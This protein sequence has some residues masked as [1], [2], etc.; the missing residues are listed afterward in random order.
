MSGRRSRRTRGEKPELVPPKSDEEAETED[1]DSDEKANETTVTRG[2]GRRGKRVGSSSSLPQLATASKKPASRKKASAKATATPK[3]K[4]G[5]PRGRPRTRSPTPSESSIEEQEDIDDASE[6]EASDAE[7]SNDPNNEGSEEDEEEEDDD[8]DAERDTEDDAPKEALTGKKKSTRKSRKKKG[9]EEADTPHPRY[10]NPVKIE[11]RNCGKLCFS[12][13]IKIHEKSCMPVYTPREDSK[14]DEASGS[15]DNSSDSSDGSSSP[16]VTARKNT[17]LCKHCGNMV[18]SR[19]F[20]QHE[21][22]CKK[23]AMDRDDDGTSENDDM[24]TK[25]VDDSSSSSVVEEDPPKKK[26]G[27]KPKAKAAPSEDDAS[28]S[29]GEEKPAKRK[30]GRKATT[31]AGDDDESLSQ[32]EKRPKKRG[33]PP[34][35]KQAADSGDDDESS[36]VVEKPPKKRGRTP[37]SKQGDDSLATVGEKTQTKRGRK[38]KA[39]SVKASADDSSS[40]SEEQP[41][42]KRG[43]K[44]KAKSSTSQKATEESDEEG[45][46][47]FSE[48]DLLPISALAM[49]KPPVSSSRGRKAD[50]AKEKKTPKNS[51]LSKA[52]AKAKTA[53]ITN[54]FSP[55][56]SGS[57]KLPVK[58]DEDENENKAGN[59]AATTPAKEENGTGKA[60]VK[61]KT[62]GD[63]ERSSET[64][65]GKVGQNDEDSG[66]EKIFSSAATTETSKSSNSESAEN[67]KEKATQNPVASPVVEKDLEK[68]SSKATTVSSTRA[69]RKRKLTMKAAAIESTKTEERKE[70]T[71]ES[72]V[73]EGSSSKDKK[74][75][76]NEDVKESNSNVD[77]TSLEGQQGIVSSDEGTTDLSKDQ[78]SSGSIVEAAK[79]AA[80]A[81]LAMF[82]LFSA[83]SKTTE[84]SKK[85][86]MESEDTGLDDETSEQSAQN[87]DKILKEDNTKTT[88]ESTSTI[89]D[90]ASL[91]QDKAIGNTVQQ[92]RA[93]SSEPQS[94]EQL[95]GKENGLL[96][97][98]SNAGPSS[99]DE[100]DATQ[101]MDI[102]STGK[103]NGDMIDNEADPNDSMPSSSSEKANGDSVKDK[104]TA[105]EATSSLEVEEVSKAGGDARKTIPDGSESSATSSSIPQ[106]TEFKTTNSEENSAKVEE[107][108]II[109]ESPS[110]KTNGDIAGNETS[111]SSAETATKDVVTAKEI[112]KNNQQSKHSA[113]ADEVPE[114]GSIEVEEKAMGLEIGEKSTD[115]QTVATEGNTGGADSQNLIED[116]KNQ[117]FDSKQ[118]KKDEIQGP[119]K[120]SAKE[121]IDI[122]QRSEIENTTESILVDVPETAQEVSAETKLEVSRTEPTKE[123]STAGKEVSSNKPSLHVSVD[124]QT[125]SKEQSDTT[126]KLNQEELAEKSGNAGQTEDSAHSLG[127]T[128]VENGNGEL[129][130][131]IK[132]NAADS[133]ETIQTEASHRESANEERPPKE[134][135]ETSLKDTE[136]TGAKMDSSVPL[137]ADDIAKAS[138]DAS[139]VAESGEKKSVSD[140]NEMVIDTTQGSSI[141]A[142]LADTAQVEIDPAVNIDV[143]NERSSELATQDTKSKETYESNTALEEA[144]N[145]GEV[146]VTPERPDSTMDVEIPTETL[147]EL[148]N[149]IPSPKVEM[150]VSWLPLSKAPRQTQSIKDNNQF[151][152]YDESKTNRVKMLLYT[153][154]SKIHRGKGFERIFGM[155]WDAVCLR[156]SRP[157]NG[158]ASKRCD[159]A[160]SAF[161]QSKKLRKIHNK[162]V[163]SKYKRTLQFNLIRGFD[164]FLI[165]SRFYKTHLN[166]YYETCV[167]GSDSIF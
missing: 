105:S 154:G 123:N 30:R 99:S 51:K 143:Q 36:S 109:P 133:D 70:G 52:A 155:Y 104:N 54:F 24:E 17:R 60:E 8:D 66:G 97:P 165:F 90:T 39:K 49:K 86:Q 37:R 152:G 115:E 71:D 124:E 139:L 1:N 55:K 25:S 81:T 122:S 167:E 32:T 113:T 96:P 166:R 161:L 67:A 91:D 78:K 102:D 9:Q 150:K 7:D 2:R 50:A 15:D 74:A 144:T 40:S 162:F 59:E 19:G 106:S 159:Q 120:E 35:A 126:T 146:K 65:G 111:Q 153:T 131:G 12:Q 31:K 117:E 134:T 121:K 61:G 151:I 119:A 85:T 92:P 53:P 20:M 73:T 11:C 21:R 107:N 164:F 83:K 26:R 4:R 89:T 6:N 3:K 23:K 138:Q 13:G 136:E 29:D 100:V 108:K 140:D 16:V 112:E 14:N 148:E 114:A 5:R 93:Q 145:A 45:S 157:L 116:T 94:N 72:K 63:T 160:I 80:A 69:T 34:K 147:S 18:S 41:P 82:P 46:D 76:E 118:H 22:S 127:N 142:P 141:E 135:E 95:S 132:P 44:P 129:S 98:T 57:A 64:T 48:E 27:R 84:E 47:R 149:D 79:N 33:R 163:M 101:P 75:S 130:E 103:D 88:S 125:E 38:P 156:L 158:N 42:K 137:Q 28:S 68:D 56:A 77:N 10:K 128:E 62:I 58:T 110:I 87:G 43:R